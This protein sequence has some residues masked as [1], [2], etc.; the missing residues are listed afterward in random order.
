MT[1]IA[2][3]ALKLGGVAMGALELAPNAT[4]DA[5]KVLTWLNNHKS[6]NG[7]G[8]EASAKNEIRISPSS[9]S[10]TTGLLNIN[11]T[12]VHNA[13][14]IASVNELVTS[15]NN[16][17]G[18]TNV[19]AR[20][21]FDGAIILSNTPGNEADKIAFGNTPGVLTGITGDYQ[22]SIV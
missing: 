3:G 10:T 21:D 16:Q 6:A 17:T 1:V 5:S 11:G 2:E 18:T 12:A 19:E 4:L 13:T 20:I 8:Y 9:L 7:L 22:S 15:I 14:P